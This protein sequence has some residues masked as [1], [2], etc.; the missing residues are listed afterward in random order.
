MSE[1]HDGRGR[2]RPA[3]RVKDGAPA[4]DPALEARE[5]ALD[6][7]LIRRAQTGDE[8]AFS[9]LV[10]RHQQRAW[11]VA[12]NLVPTDEDAQDL[13]QEAFVRVFK[14]I[15]SF[16][17]DHAF[18]TWLYRIVT[19][20]AIDH[21][22]R[23]RPVTSTTAGEDDEAGFDIVDTR[24]AGP[25]QALET[26]ELAGEVHATLAGLAP[27]FQS[28][29]ILREMEGLPCNEIAKIVGATHVTVRWRLHRGRKLFQEEW[30]RRARLREL[31]GDRLESGEKS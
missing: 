9:D 18:T 12:R 15:A 2:R 26:S 24:I 4:A 10:T 20:L 13:A 27:H 31:G 1:N 8:H 21:L 30:E 17:F 29:L 6:H 22:R 19:N 11:R 7:A 23:R 28:V 5:I 16:D 3:P 25:S 14:S